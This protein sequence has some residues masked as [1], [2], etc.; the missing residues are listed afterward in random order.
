MKTIR[1]RS[2]TLRG[3]FLFW[4]SRSSLVSISAAR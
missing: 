3:L 2:T 1:P 4:A